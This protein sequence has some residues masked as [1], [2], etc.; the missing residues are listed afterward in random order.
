MACGS[1][2]NYT[3]KLTS[4]QVLWLRIRLHQI[5]CLFFKL[6]SL[7]LSQTAPENAEDLVVSR[8]TEVKVKEINTWYLES[9]SPTKFPSWAVS[10]WLWNL[11]PVLI[12]LFSEAISKFIT[13]SLF[14]RTAFPKLSRLW[15]WWCVSINCC[16]KELVNCRT[17]FHLMLAIVNWFQKQLWTYL[18]TA[19]TNGFD[20]KLVDKKI[21][22][23]RSLKQIKE[24]TTLSTL[25]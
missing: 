7:L 1:Q 14:S 12:K 13:F 8:H 22:N 16:Y 25:D 11:V 9:L 20:K 5:Y 6:Y 24:T 18:N 2:L 17:S 19:V 21:T 23:F 15:G 4:R 3:L 10:D